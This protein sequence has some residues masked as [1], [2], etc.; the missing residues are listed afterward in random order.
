MAAIDT[1]RQPPNYYRLKMAVFWVVAPCSLV[2][3]Y[4]RFRGLCCLHHQGDTYY[5]LLLLRL[6]YRLLIEMHKSVTNSD[7]D[8]FLDYWLHK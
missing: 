2:E 3:V 4:H 6:P 5:R 8:G 7:M 1:D